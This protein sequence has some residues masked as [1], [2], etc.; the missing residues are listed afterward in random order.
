MSVEYTPTASS[1]VV[2]LNN[3]KFLAE[4]FEVNKK[5]A[6][7]STAGFDVWYNGLKN[8]I[9][10]AHNVKFFTGSTKY[11]FNCVEFARVTFENGRA[12][13]DKT[14][15]SPETAYTPGRSGTL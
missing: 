10:N 14:V 1:A 11:T 6:N 4:D 8:C 15:Y 12:I 9:H 13:I 7:D 5:N 2:E 3:I